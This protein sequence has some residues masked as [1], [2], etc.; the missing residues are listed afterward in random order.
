M[1]PLPVVF[2]EA[3]KAE[4]K[5]LFSTCVVNPR[6]IGICTRIV[7]AINANKMRYESIAGEVGC[8]WFLVGLIHNMECGLSF[9]KHLHN[10]DLLTART[11]NVPAGRIPA[12]AEPPFTFEDSAHDALLLR[13]FDKWH[14]WKI[15]GILWM[16]EQ[17]NG[18]GYRQYHPN[19]K[20]PYLWSFTNHYSR[21]KYVQDGNFSQSAISNQLGTAAILKTGVAAGIFVS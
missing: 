14:D 12:P 18:L 8:P 16:L 15:E 5:E 3:L 9:E 10:G 1:P 21:G 19:V 13:Q 4:Y 7:K 6:Y 11:H 20:S 2:N 17:Y